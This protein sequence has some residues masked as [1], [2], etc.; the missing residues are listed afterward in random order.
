[1][2]HYRVIWDEPGYELLYARESCRKC[3]G[4]GK[5]GIDGVHGKMILCKCIVKGNLV[6][7]KKE[8]KIIPA[9]T[10]FGYKGV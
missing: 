5:T 3:H 9:G 1:M 10:P 6:S 2:R 4:T 8:V 7:N